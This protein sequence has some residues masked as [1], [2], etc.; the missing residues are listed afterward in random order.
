MTKISSD[1]K[2]WH[3]IEINLVNK[4]RQSIVSSQLASI[5]EFIIKIKTR[6]V[7]NIA[8]HR[9]ISIL[10]KKSFSSKIKL[11]KYAKLHPV[12]THI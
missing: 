2:I 3:S 1:K 9:D 7:I 11:A 4:K 12:L 6:A 10:M 8:K 5:V